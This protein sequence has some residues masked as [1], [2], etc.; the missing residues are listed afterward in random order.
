MAYVEKPDARVVDQVYER[1]IGGRPARF[2]DFENASGY[3][4]LVEF[5]FRRDS[6]FHRPDYILKPFTSQIV[7]PERPTNRVSWVLTSAL[8]QTEGAGSVTP[9]FGFVASP[10]IMSQSPPTHQNVGVE[11]GVSTSVK[12]VINDESGPAEVILGAQFITQ[13]NR[14][15]EILTDGTVRVGNGIT[16]PGNAL[17]PHS[18]GNGKME[19]VLAPRCSADPT[20]VSDLAR[21]GYVDAAIEA[22]GTGIPVGGTLLWFAT[23]L[24]SG[25]IRPTGQ[26]LVRADFPE[27]FAVLGTTYNVG[28]IAATDFMVPDLRGRTF[29]GDGTGTGLSPRVVAD[30]LGA[31][32]HQLTTGQLPSHNHGGSTANA[33]GHQ[34]ILTG[35]NWTKNLNPGGQNSQSGS[36]G[37]SS[38]SWT[39]VDNPNVDTSGVH[40]HTINNNG[41]DAAH[42]NMQPSI[43]GRYIMKSVP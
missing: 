7:L 10:Q 2:F 21:K 18:A 1:E 38:V 17:F 15:I 28:N 42:N 23:A 6:L 20:N 35:T 31:E 19:F 39:N 43:V 4:A 36:G 41:S 11:G 22:A 27:L 24:P 9:Y 32:T 26:V 14:T 37:P 5:G 33:G 13:A 34:H 3:Y 25:F 40:D 29:I 8:P 16:P 12:A 30:I